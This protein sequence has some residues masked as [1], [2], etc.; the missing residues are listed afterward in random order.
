MAIDYS[1]WHTVCDT[2]RYLRRHLQSEPLLNPT[3]NVGRT[4]YPELQFVV[5]KDLNGLA[6]TDIWSN[7]DVFLSKVKGGLK[8][9]HPIRS[10]SD[11]HSES[12]NRS[13]ILI[14]REFFIF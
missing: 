14:K 1:V 6:E 5:N 11:T 12:V 7:I 10:S 9:D 4:S 2:P 3:V 8:C 13:I